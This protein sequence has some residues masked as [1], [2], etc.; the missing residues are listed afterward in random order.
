[1]LYSA[2]N[3]SETISIKIDKTI[4]QVSNKVKLLGIILDD[5]LDFKVHITTLSE[6]AIQ[7]LHALSSVSIFV[8]TNKFKQVMKAAIIS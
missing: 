3:C 8:N 5:K 7:N 2:R 4:L 1:M 6:K